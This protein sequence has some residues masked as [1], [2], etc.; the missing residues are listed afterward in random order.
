[1]SYNYTAQ[2]IDTPRS[3][4]DDTVRVFDQFYNF[5]LQ[6]N[7]DQYEIVYSYFYDLNKSKD[8]ARNFTTILFRIASITGED[9]LKLLEYLTG[10]TNIEVNGILIYYLN[11]LKSKTTLY[12]INV[13][14]VPNQS[15]QRNIIQ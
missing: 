5:D 13:E 8:I 14:P 1:M 12:G 7:A 3:H 15:V 9:V 2:I 11:S 6:V 4:L 10:S